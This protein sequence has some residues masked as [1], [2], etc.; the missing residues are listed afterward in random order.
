MGEFDYLDKIAIDRESSAVTIDSFLSF[1]TNLYYG[2]CCYFSCFLRNNRFLVDNFRSSIADL[3]FKLFT[4][5][6]AVLRTSFYQLQPAEVNS[7]NHANCD[8]YDQAHTIFSFKWTLHSNVYDAALK[9]SFINSI[10]PLLFGT[11]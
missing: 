1:I 2:I 3:F 10:F 5:L 4:D 7:G 9:A 8:P 11:C 6:L